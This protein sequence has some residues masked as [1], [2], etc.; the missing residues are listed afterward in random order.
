MNT[1]VLQEPERLKF[2]HRELPSL[3]ENESARVRVRRIGV[4]GTDLHAFK[5]DQPFFS[6]PRVLGHELGVEVLE[7][8]AANDIIG[9]GDYC[10]VEPYLNCGVCLTCKV[11]KT[12]CCE[13]L[14]VIG[15]HE[16]GGMTEEI[17]IPV[18]KLHKSSILPLEHLALVEM[19]SIGAHAV[20][21]AQLK[22]QDQVLVIGAGPIG[23]SVIQFAK[24]AGVEPV[25]FEL[26]DQRRQFCRSFP[27][28]EIC[29]A[30]E[31]DSVAQL[32]ALM[33]GRLPD[34]VFDATGHSGSMHRSFELVG[35]GGKLVFVGLTLGDISFHNPEFHRKEMTLLSSRNATSSDFDYVIRML[36]TGKV[37]LTPWITHRA[38][39]SNVLSEFPKWLHRDE[40]VVK[41]MID[42][43]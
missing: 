43:D 20:S 37:N 40:G 27:G 5:G 21:R 36:E 9:V 29:V 19:L 42:L 38:S 25:V 14:K 41:A 7:V 4:C 15:V 13:H 24:L 12:N 23:L 3:L 30:P 2:E 35:A 28:V 31:E 34:V 32:S 22:A 16:D 10:A 26:D 6:Y 8:D 18:N 33:Q 11:G 39:F 17:I 1:L